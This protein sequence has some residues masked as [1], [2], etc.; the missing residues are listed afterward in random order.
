MRT[1]NLI[2]TLAEDNG[3]RDPVTAGEAGR[4]GVLSPLQNG[5]GRALVVVF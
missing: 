5:S 4:G 1:L 2:V 3:E